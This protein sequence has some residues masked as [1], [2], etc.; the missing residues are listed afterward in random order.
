MFSLIK[1]LS[2]CAAFAHWASSGHRSGRKRDHKSEITNPQGVFSYPGRETLRDQLLRRRSVAVSVS[3]SGRAV[4][5]VCVQRRR[6]E[7]QS[8]PDLRSPAAQEGPA[9]AK[10]AGQCRAEVRKSHLL[11]L[12]S[13]FIPSARSDL[14]SLIQ[15]YISSVVDFSNRYIN[16]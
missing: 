10:P 8:E 14:R 9:A 16:A 15:N 2:N 12:L 4:L 7:N 3:D 11:V 13:G 6:C 1:H 5:A